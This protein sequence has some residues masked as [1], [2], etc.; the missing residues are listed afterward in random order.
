MNE[1]TAAFLVA[2]ITLVTKYGIPGVIQILQDWKVDN[3]TIED[4]EALKLR[5]PRPETYFGG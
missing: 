1:T 3:P 2:L 4:I 5:V